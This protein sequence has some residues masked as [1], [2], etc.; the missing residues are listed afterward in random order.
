[1]PPSTTN[2]PGAAS[3]SRYGRVGSR[4]CR[5]P[6][7]R[8]DGKPSRASSANRRVR[9]MPSWPS[10]TRV[11]YG[12]TVWARDCGRFI[13]GA[14]PSWGSGPAGECRHVRAAWLDPGREAAYAC[15][16]LRSGARTVMRA[17]VRQLP[18]CV[19]DLGTAAVPVRVVRLCGCGG[20]PYAGGSR[21]RRTAGGVRRSGSRPDRPSRPPG[22][23]PSRP[24]SRSARAPRGP[25]DCRN[26]TLPSGSRLASTQLPPL[27]PL[28]GLCQPSVPSSDAG[29]PLWTGLSVAM[30]HNSLRSAARIVP[31]PSDRLRLY[32]HPVQYLQI[33]RRRRRAGRSNCAPARLSV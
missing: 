29:M 20:A 24:G 22:T 12:A 9:R 1:M 21:R 33:R 15:R 3:S 11:R 8:R 23:P 18:Q 25:V 17:V 5:P 19:R 26:A 32:G 7:S 10:T 14:S 31:G 6:G 2:R 4:W 13:A 16:S 27:V 28:Q 30:V